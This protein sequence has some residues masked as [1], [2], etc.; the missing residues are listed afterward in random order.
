VT[1]GL[2]E[3]FGPLPGAQPSGHTLKK[4][5]KKKKFKPGCYAQDLNGLLCPGLP[6]TPGFYAQECCLVLGT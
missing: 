5:K 3:L 1:A 6:F 4:K 2:G